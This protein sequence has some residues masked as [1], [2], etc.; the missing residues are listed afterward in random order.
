MKKRFDEIM[1]RSERFA[2]RIWDSCSWETVAISLFFSIMLSLFLLDYLLTKVLVPSVPAQMLGCLAYLWDIPISNRLWSV[3]CCICVTPLLFLGGLFAFS[4][5]GKELREN[6]VRF[7]ALSLAPILYCLAL[8]KFKIHEAIDLSWIIVS[9]LLFF[10]VF[11]LQFWKKQCVTGKDYTLLFC[12]FFIPFG[13]C[14]L[15]RAVCF[16]W[17][18][19]QYLGFYD[20]GRLKL[21]KLPYC[22]F[23]LTLILLSFPKNGAE[24]Y[25]R[26]LC[27]V[28]QLLV[29]PLFAW[30]LPAVYLRDGQ[31]IV[32]HSFDKTFWWIVLPLVLLGA[33]DIL[34]RVWKPGCLKRDYSPF[35]LIAVLAYWKFDHFSV[36]GLANFFEFGDR[37]SD[38]Y[39]VRSGVMTIFKDATPCYGLWDYFILRLTEFF[40]DSFTMAD[41][42]GASLIG[43]FALVISFYIFFYFLPI[44]IAF[45]IS[46][47]LAEWF[48]GGGFLAV[49][50]ALIIIWIHPDIL[51]RRVLWCVLW[52]ITA[53]AVVFFKIS[54]GPVLAA[55]FLPLFLYQFFHVFKE[56]KK[57]GRKLLCF[58]IVWAFLFFVWPFSEYF[59]GLLRLV[60][61]TA[62]VN[63][64]WAA[65]AWQ[66]GSGAPLPYIAANAIIF[67]PVLTVFLS[68]MFLVTDLPM[69]S[70]N[71]KTFAWG[72][73]SASL[74]YTFFSL[75][76][77]YS[78]MDEL[79]CRQT[80]SFMLL[81]PFLLVPL[82]QL[83]DKFRH[84][85]NLLLVL[86]LTPLIVPS[87]IRNAEAPEAPL[88]AIRKPIPEINDEDMVRGEDFDLPRA[89][90]GFA[91]SMLDVPKGCREELQAERE[92]KDIL[93]RV[94]APGET[95]LNLS[96]YGGMYFL[97]DR[98][99]PARHSNY[100]TVTGDLTQYHML[101]QLDGKDVV[102][103]VFGRDCFDSSYPMLRSFYLFRYAIRDSLPLKVNDQYF[104]LMPARYFE[105]I[106]RSVPSR[107]EALA[108]WDEFFNGGTSVFQFDNLVYSPAVWGRNCK[109]LLKAVSEAQ[110]ELP[111]PEG[112][113]LQQQIRFREPLSGDQWGILE[114]DSANECWAG[115]TWTNE[116]EKPYKICFKL[117]PG[118]NLVPLDAYP[119]WFQ[120]KENRELSFFSQDHELKI[121]GVTIHRRKMPP[122]IERK[123][124]VE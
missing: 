49:L 46:I 118:K 2:R 10:G 123:K 24:R 33:T 52:S 122:E 53:S 51:K 73:F 15:A 98:P 124:T 57:L 47:F 101:K 40:S 41:T 72:L 34:V 4:L 87:I 113:P 17:Y 6:M 28:L 93:D 116:F 19:E 103:S 35:P 63:S 121:T 43:L 39:A 88:N 11:W 99:L 111:L 21:S 58:E 50:A 105:K 32:L 22:S 14:C 69:A 119:Y 62:S 65:T 55:A 56:D 9:C 7:G 86:S 80:R 92:V 27:A 102:V 94:L 82:F 18:P 66:Y 85:R 84:L 117:A 25:R 77:S 31:P 26:T 70:D 59:Y 61:E 83:P 91:A 20:W 107:E 108:I 114:I 100:Y 109:K 104:I 42:Y 67:L 12:S 5:L 8:G 30:L 95:F 79:F 54:Q 110:M 1:E 78:R 75:N 36:I 29:L 13:F 68:G 81:I 3:G 38:Y 64:A 23:G 97:F 76:Y 89:G 74:C 90:Y 71:R 48:L 44:W 106:G 45:L 37:I 112:E 96:L 60:Y 115:V 16:R 120:A